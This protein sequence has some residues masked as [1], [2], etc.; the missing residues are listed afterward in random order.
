[1]TPSKAAEVDTK[2]GRVARVSYQCLFL[3]SARCYEVLI[4]EVR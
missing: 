2:S 1:M 4:G 3:C